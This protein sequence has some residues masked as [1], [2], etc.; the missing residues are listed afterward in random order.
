MAY[1]PFAQA[2]ITPRL[3]REP[4]PLTNAEQDEVVQR[5]REIHRLKM[6][7]EKISRATTYFANG[8]VVGLVVN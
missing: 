7:Y 2:A 6:A 1:G 3:K 5:R 4:L 8:A